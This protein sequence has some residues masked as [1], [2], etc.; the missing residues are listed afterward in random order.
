[1]TIPPQNL[2]DDETMAVLF[3]IPISDL[4]NSK[5]RLRHIREESESNC[6]DPTQR[7]P[8]T[9]T[10]IHYG[11]VSAT[12]SILYTRCDDTSQRH[13]A[14][15][16]QRCPGYVCADASALYRSGGI[17]EKLCKDALER[18]SV[19]CQLSCSR[20]DAQDSRRGQIAVAVWGRYDD[21]GRSFDHHGGLGD[22]ARGV[23]AGWDCR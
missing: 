10:T 16:V 15:Q 2:E 6:G 18:Q 20:Q 13:L 9:P 5:M 3:D 22:C 4:A 23:S 1:M 7:A 14:G 21:S 12:S 17:Q 8:W 19:G 11:A